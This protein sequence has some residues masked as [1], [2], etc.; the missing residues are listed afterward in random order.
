MDIQARIPSALCV[1]H[2]C[3]REH[4][5]EEGPL[6]SNTFLDRAHFAADAGV[7][8]A[9]EPVET[10][11]DQRRE[12]IADAM[13]ADYQRVLA[14]RQLAGDEPLSTESEFSCV[15]DSAEEEE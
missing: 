4:D 9:D 7:G 3:I 8:G 14:E 2:N 11:H 12:N 15:S 5:P 10:L 1:I 13:W 6:E